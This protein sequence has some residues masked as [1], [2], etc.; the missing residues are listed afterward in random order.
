M[1]GDAVVGMVLLAAALA[2]LV[3][4]VFWSRRRIERI[5]RNGYGTARA[6]EKEL[7]GG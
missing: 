5:S 6:I 4:L 3:V 1:E 7:D 2:S